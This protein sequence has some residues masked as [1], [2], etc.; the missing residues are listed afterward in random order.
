MTRLV[1]KVTSESPARLPEIPDLRRELLQ[2]V[3]TVLAS[4]TYLQEAGLLL[5]LLARVLLLALHDGSTLLYIE[6]KRTLS[7]LSP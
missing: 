6:P 7:L 4:H 2:V 5:A 3:I 1:A